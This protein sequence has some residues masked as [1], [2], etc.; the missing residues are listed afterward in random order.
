MAKIGKQKVNRSW[1]GNLVVLIILLLFGT[2]LA[3]PIVYTFVSA[4][5]P[6]DEIFTFPPK[7]YVVR[8]TLENFVMMANIIS[9]SWVP[10]TRYIFNSFFITGVSTVAHVIFASMAAYPL[11]KHNFFGKKTLNKLIVLALL[12]TPSVTYI[13]QYVVMSQL[14]L[15][16]TYA[17]VMLPFMALPLGLFLMTSFMQSIPTALLEAARIDGTSEFQCFW[18]IVMPVVKPAWLTLAIFAFQMTW[19]VTGS[20]FIY[21]E[22]L[23]SLT[24][25]LEPIAAA[26]ISRAGVGAA[27]SLFLLIPPLLL[28]VFAQRHVI[29]TMASSGIK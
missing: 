2:F 20:T 11:A 29:E 17:A 4:F 19:Q 9:N 14:G 6:L 3:L 15:I 5:K 13:P 1:G 18:K 22:S 12:F 25:V 8:P 23:K 24:Y 16:N 26:G 7:L 10:L 28:F 27:V 21:D